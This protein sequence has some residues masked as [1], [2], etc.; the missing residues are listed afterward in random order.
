MSK[1]G[2]ESRLWGKSEA[3]VNFAGRMTF[4][5]RVKMDAVH[6]LVEES[7]AL[8]RCVVDAHP[9]DRLGV[10]VRPVERTN[11]FGRI[12]RPGG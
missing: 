9:L 3:V 6:A 10:G 1:G 12:A 8:F 2:G 7:G 4:V 5:E 11:Q